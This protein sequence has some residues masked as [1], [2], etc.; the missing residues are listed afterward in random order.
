MRLRLGGRLP[1]FSREERELLSSGS[2]SGDFYGMNT[3]VSG[4]CCGVM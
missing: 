2:S 1:I 3:Y 4:F